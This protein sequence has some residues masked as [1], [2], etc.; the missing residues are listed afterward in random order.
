MTRKA[1]LI[2]WIVLVGFTA[3]VAFFAWTIRSSSAMNACAVC[4]RHIHPETRTVAELEGR[5]AVFC[6]PTCARM[7][8]EQRPGSARIVELTDDETGE[9]LNPEDAFL[10]VGSDVNYCMRKHVY[11][12]EE[13]QA[14]MMDFD[15]CSPS[16]IA[17]AKRAAAAE[18]VERHGGQLIR[19]A[20][21]AAAVP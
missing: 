6:C 4:N 19:F 3:G 14:A 10:V 1:T 16:V 12:N 7:A 21:L 9:R 5:R 20:D 17:F 8:G 2:G 15:R 11:L 18:F 13:K